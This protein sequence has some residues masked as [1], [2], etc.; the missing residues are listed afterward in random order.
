MAKKRRLGVLKRERGE[1]G[2]DRHLGGGSYI[3]SGWA[4]RPYCTAHGHV[5]DWVTLL[6]NRTW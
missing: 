6:H 1:S 4:M 5:C 2:M 3:W